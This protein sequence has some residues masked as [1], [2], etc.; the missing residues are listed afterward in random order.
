MMIFLK[1]KNEKRGKSMIVVCEHTTKLFGL[2]L[3]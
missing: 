1:I 2:V 3:V